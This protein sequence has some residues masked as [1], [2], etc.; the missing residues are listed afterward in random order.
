MSKLTVSAPTPACRLPDAVSSSWS[1]RPARPLR[2]QPCSLAALAQP[3][4]K[5]KAAENYSATAKVEVR[6]GVHTAD[7]ASVTLAEAGELWIATAEKN[8]L[9]RSTIAA[10]RQHLDLHIAPYLGRV[11]C[12]SSARPWCGTSRTRS[13]QA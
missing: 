4:L 6:A 1:A 8:R 11:R 7:S 3:P 12:P 9:E 13:P 5:K 2:P 10:Y